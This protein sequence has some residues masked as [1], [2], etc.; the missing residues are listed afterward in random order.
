[1]I[2]SRFSL[3]K[4]G[5]WLWIFFLLALRFTF[6]GDTVFIFDEPLFQLKLD[7]HIA[8]GT[9]PLTSFRG[10]SIPLP[11]GAGAM[12]F[13]YLA[14]LFFWHPYVLV[15]YHIS[16]VTAGALLFLST[17]RKKFGEEGARWSGLLL[18]SSPL[19]FYFSRH[20]W[21]NTLLFTVGAILVWCLVQLEEQKREYLYHAIMGAA[22]GYA[23]NI[24]LMF[25]PV[26]LAL[27][28]T[29]KFRAWKLYGIKSKKFW[30]PLLLFGATALLLLSPYLWEAFHIMQIEQPLEHTKY[31]KRWGDGRNLWWLVQRSVIFSSVWGSRIYLDTVHPQFEAFVG[32]PLA[33]LFHNDIFGWFAKIMALV[34]VL[35]YPYRYFS[36]KEK[37]DALKFFAVT[38]FFSMILVLHFLNIP[39][40]PH[41]FHSVWWLVFVGIAIA[42]PKLKGGWKKFFL[43]SILLTALVNTAFILSSLTF[44]HLNKGA[45]NYQFSVS[46]SEQLRALREICTEASARIPKEARVDLADAFILGPGFVYLPKHMPECKDVKF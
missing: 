40:A 3:S 1:M 13:Y 25:G 33:F 35:A 39:T 20:P 38:S 45:R 18:A 42:V 34:T 21:D 24:H 44:L 9:F 14:R 17:A 27:G 46:V 5:I 43:A 10:S 23:L 2:N 19:L 12:W 28:F 29:L 37:F 15:L 30:L 22:V 36:G 11:Y 32:R 7:D 31:T 26:A 16:A 6:W 8:N 4:E 41:Y